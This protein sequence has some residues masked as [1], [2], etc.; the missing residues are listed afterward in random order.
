MARFFFHLRAGDLFIQ[1][2]AGVELEDYR[3]C[4]QHLML[5]LKR[6]GSGDHRGWTFEVFDENGELVDSIPVVDLLG[7]VH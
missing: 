1:D 3:A 5:I 2:M 4:A 7:A 6:P